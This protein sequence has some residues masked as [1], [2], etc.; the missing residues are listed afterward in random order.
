[1]HLVSLLRKLAAET[2]GATGSDPN[3]FR[4]AADAYEKTKRLVEYVAPDDSRL[5][6]QGQNTDRD[7]N[8][9]VMGV[10]K[11]LGG[12]I[13]IRGNMGDGDVLATATHEILTHGN[14]EI[15]NQLEDIQARGQDRA[16]LQLLPA[17]LR[18]SAML[19]RQRVALF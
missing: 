7:P 6:P 11:P 3:P 5:D 12:P 2:D 1:M 8:T 4:S 15:P 19:W 17:R 13:Y 14:S 18:A 10:T 9:F 16:I